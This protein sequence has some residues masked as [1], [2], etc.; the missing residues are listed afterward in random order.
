MEVQRRAEIMNI[1][2]LLVAGLAF[3]ESGFRDVTS[4]K[5]AKGIMQ[6]M[7]DI[8]CEDGKPCDLIDAGLE[9]LQYWLTRTRSPVRAICHYNSGNR[10]KP[11]GARWSVRVIETV[12]KLHK[13]CEENQMPPKKKRKRNY[14]KEY[15]RDHSSTKAKKDRAAR[16]KANRKLKP[17]PGKEVDHKKPLSKGGGNGKKNLR[18]VKRSTNRKKGAKT[19]KRKK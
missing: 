16:N 14:R 12:N 4:R 3:H 15:D 18:V 6:V 13:A 17:G 1:D 2:P 8:H 11:A 10:C 19:T 5:G 9:Y 7:E